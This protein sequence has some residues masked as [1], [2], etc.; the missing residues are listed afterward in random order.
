MTTLLTKLASGLLTF[1]LVASFVPAAV[2]AQGFELGVEDEPTSAETTTEEVETSEEHTQP[3]TIT[4]PDFTVPGEG[5]ED[6]SEPEGDIVFDEDLDIV[7]EDSEEVVVPAQRSVQ[8]DV[9][10]AAVS[11]TYQVIGGDINEL[12]QVINDAS[13]GETIEVSGSYTGNL[14]IGTRVSVV[15]MQG[16][17]ASLT[18]QVTISANDVTFSGFEV[19]NPNGSNGIVINGASNVTVSGNTLTQIGSSLTEGSAQAIY[20]VGAT[21]MSNIGPFSVPSCSPI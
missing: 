6:A 15:E 7:I 11:V 9:E 12:Q 1:A 3:G 19:T 5:T 21:A 13:E 18:G 2:F 8:A 14:V 16:E 10:T 17:T 20:I 4:T